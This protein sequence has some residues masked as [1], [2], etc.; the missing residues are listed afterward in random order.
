M[1]RIFSILMCAVI[2]CCSVFAMAGCTKQNE[3]KSDIVLITSGGDIHDDGCNQSAWEGISEY[4]EE[5]LLSC[6]YYQPALENDEL[7]A[8]DIEKYVE[9]SAK[10]GAKYIVFPSEEFASVTYE[11]APLYPDINFILLDAIPRA[12]GDDT[13]AFLTNV[14]SVKFDALQSGILAGYLAVASGNTELGYFGEFESDTSANYGAGFVQGAAMVA[15]TKGIPV[16]VDWAD[17]DSPLLDYDYSFTV[18]ACYDKI[19][20]S[21][22]KVYNVKVENGKGTGSYKEGSNVTITANPAPVGK[23]FDKWEVKS[24]TDGVKDKKVNVSSKKNESM[25]LLVEECDCTITAVYK[26]IEGESVVVKTMGAQ[27]DTVYLE[28]SAP[29]NSTVDIK[30]PVA[31]KDMVFD[32]WDCSVA[33]AVEDENSAQ[34]RLNVSEQDVVVTPVYTVSNTPTFN[35]NVVTGEG[36]DGD[37][38]GSGSYVAGDMVEVAAAAPAE[39]YMFSHWTN[40]DVYGQSTGVAMENE[41]YWNTTFEMADRYASVCK[42]MYNHGVSMIFNGGNSKAESALTA[43]WSFDYDLGVIAAG[44]KNKDS[45]T[46][47]VKNYG[48]AV[49]ICLEDYKGG[50]VLA[51]NCS[52][53]GIY[54]SYVPEEAQEGYDNLYTSLAE[55]K[56]KPIMVEGGAGS[57][58]CRI[59]VENKL[60]KCLTLNGWFKEG[61]AFKVK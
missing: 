39:G 2:V 14:M 49:K 25:N 18:T 1:K 55:G 10:N 58:F 5:N 27:T 53:E 11:L 19:D 8:A 47:I 23:V 40:E 29:I 28:Q 42:T 52:N 34:T 12:A 31:P 35:I 60:S 21:N 26:D 46:T 13:D 30:A 50:S 17:Y 44:E 48:K 16:T 4:A 41:Y 61:F 45:F 22:G 24:D 6:R 57:E 32:H 3:L 51:A 54:A 43:K 56:E 15:D 38:S 7:T 59:F 37:S 33:D 36:G 20:E 9:L